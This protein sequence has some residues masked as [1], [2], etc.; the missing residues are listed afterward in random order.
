MVWDAQKK[1]GNKDSLLG[2]RGV[3]RLLKGSAGRLPSVSV[4]NYIYRTAERADKTR[5]RR[6]VRDFQKKD[7]HVHLNRWHVRIRLNWVYWTDDIESHQISGHALDRIM[8][9]NLRENKT[10]D[11]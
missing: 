11:I 5:R 7:V 2:Y 6:R 10:T 4:P 8:T 3:W 1:I 9:N